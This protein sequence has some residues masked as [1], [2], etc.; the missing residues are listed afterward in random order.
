MTRVSLKDF[1]PGYFWDHHV[2][3][4]A[5]DTPKNLWVTAKEN[6]IS[7]SN[8]L[9][10]DNT[11]HNFQAI[12]ENTDKDADHEMYLNRFK[13]MHTIQ[14][15]PSSV[16]KSAFNAAAAAYTKSKIGSFEV[17]MNPI[18][19]N[20]RKEF[21]IDFIIFAALTG[22]RKAQMFFNMKCG[23]ILEM[24]RS[25]SE[26]LNSIIVNKAMKYTDAGV[27]GIDVSGSSKNI[28]NFNFDPFKTAYEFANNMDLNTT[29]HAGEV[30][31]PEE[32]WYALEE[33]IPKRI[34]H[35]IMAYK[36]EDQKLK[37]EFKK[38]TKA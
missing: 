11:Y 3:L 33:L 31:G 21:D 35:G 17:R 24:D 38:T 20:P 16:E 30:Y 2:H 29:V 27:V 5:C 18:L 23:L 12:V 6:G 15:S 9:G 13:L 26:E 10:V 36:D 7:L 28:K 4:G 25:F 37:K 14:S 19:R 22:L 8:A 32:I 34:G 1:A